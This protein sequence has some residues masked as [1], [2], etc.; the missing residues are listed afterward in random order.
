MIPELACADSVTH[1]KLTGDMLMACAKANYGRP[2]I[3]ISCDAHPSHSLTVSF[4]MGLSPMAK[5]AG[6]PFWSNTSF[7]GYSLPAWPFRTMCFGQPG[8]DRY[9]VHMCLDATHVRKALVRSLR[10][11]VRVWTL[12]GLFVN[13]AC[14]AIRGL[15]HCSFS[16]RDGQSDREAALC[17]LPKFIPN[18]WDSHGVLFAQLMVSLTSSQ[19]LCSA[20]HRRIHVLENALTGFYWLLLTLWFAW[21]MGQS[22]WL[23]WFLHR[24]TLRN[25]ALL[26]A[27]LCTLGMDFPADLPWVPSK[28]QEWALETH[29]SKVKRPFT[30]TPSI[31]DAILSTQRLH[32]SQYSKIDVD[33]AEHGRF[34]T[35]RARIAFGG[36]G[37]VSYGQLLL[38][39]LDHD[40]A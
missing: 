12:G 19:W 2:P 7:E 39:G 40:S 33:G 10:S 34:K 20:S 8:T 26:S 36:S 29:F 27:Q 37:W 1:F 38:L 3:A 17:L 35:G 32:M 30:G 15:P 11:A 6:H 4:V 5:A 9:P 21:R 14:L 28:C 24:I 23:D 31:K 18:T 13:M 16:G 22:K 25:T